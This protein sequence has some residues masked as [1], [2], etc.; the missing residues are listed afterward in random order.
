VW[1]IV[2]IMPPR[3]RELP[4]ANR[5][6]EREM[7]EL[8]AQLETMEAAQRRAPDVGDVS[9]AKSEEV[10]LKKLQ[11]RRLHKNVC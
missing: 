3:R 8:R 5:V 10:R 6:V 9:D 4:L 1:Q 11:E 7:R 2:N